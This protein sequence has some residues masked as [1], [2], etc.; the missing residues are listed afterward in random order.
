MKSMIWP[1][2]I[3]SAL[4]RF[5]SGADR[6]P[7]A[8]PATGPVPDTAPARE[9]IRIQRMAVGTAIDNQEISGAGSDF[10]ASVGK[11]YCW[12]KVTTKAPPTRFKHVWYADGHQEA[13]IT[14]EVQYPTVRT[15]STKSIWPGSWKVDAVDESGTVLSSVEFKVRG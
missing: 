15:W 14:L 6:M 10:K 1:L 13:S 9:S 8:S 12:N 7:A 11:V 5:S 3:L 4:T 2:L